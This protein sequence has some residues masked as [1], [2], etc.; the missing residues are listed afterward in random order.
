MADT[1]L[2]WA[3]TLP[4]PE[5]V[6]ADV[7]AGRLFVTVRDECALDIAGKAFAASD[8]TLVQMNVIDVSGSMVYRKSENGRPDTETIWMAVQEVKGELKAMFPSVYYIAFSHVATEVD[9]DSNIC[10]CRAYS[11]GTSYAEPFGLAARLR[12]PKCNILFITD[13]ESQSGWENQCTL[14]K[15]GGAQITVVGYGS[16][17]SEAGENVLRKISNTGEPKFLKN[18]SEPPV[19]F[20]LFG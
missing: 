19:Q 16:G 2:K 1:W 11:G 6:E 5:I 13:G 12:H 18:M 10:D 3:C 9:P 14:L 15:Q 7:D 4:K 20:S 17:L 8:D